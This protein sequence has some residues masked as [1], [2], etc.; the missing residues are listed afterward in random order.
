MPRHA[1]FDR[2]VARKRDQTQGDVL[3]QSACAIQIHR[4]PEMEL[5][6]DVGARQPPTRPRFGH[7]KIGPLTQRER[8]NFPK[9]SSVD[10]RTDENVEG[11]HLL[12]HQN[13]P[14]SRIPRRKENQQR[15]IAGEKD[16]NLGVK[17]PG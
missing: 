7:C 16:P 9:V 11:D 15:K 5:T 6:V 1:V 3:P 12:H 14:L 17:V 8:A 10:A 2:E 4:L 13:R